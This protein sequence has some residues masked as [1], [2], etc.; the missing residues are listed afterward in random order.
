MKRLVLSLLL[1]G[2]LLGPR[3]ILAASATVRSGAL[4]MPA[5]CALVTNEHPRLLFRQRDLTAYKGRIA[6]P[7]AE[8]FQR[9]RAWWDR[10]IA[11]PGYDWKSA[12][13]MDGV[14][15]GV[16]YQLT[17]QRRYADAVRRSSLLQTGSIFWAYHFAVDLV[18]DTLSPEEIRQQADLF[19]KGA[20]EKY[21][22]NRGW[23]LWPAIVLHGAA[24][25]RE[26]QVAKWLEQ[27]VRGAAERIAEADEWAA[28]RGGDVNSFSY[29]RWKSHPDYSQWTTDP[30]RR[31]VVLGTSP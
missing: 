25:G 13:E 26:A 8:D 31:S 18:F 5:D 17:G 6:G 14:A 27:G 22:Y 20:D 24:S 23:A 10:K 28:N 19:L 12:E 3:T 9:F 2:G 16:L 7:M 4:E 1:A 29:V 11:V 30:F 15:L 21:R